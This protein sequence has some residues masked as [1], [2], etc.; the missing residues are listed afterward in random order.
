MVNEQHVTEDLRVQ[1]SAAVP[2]LASHTGAIAL[3]DLLEVL[4][5]VNDLVASLAGGFESEFQDSV[6]SGSLDNRENELAHTRLD[7]YLDP[8]WTW[9]R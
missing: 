9:R 6:E 1:A 3:G 8:A 4:P 2:G 7:H 5:P